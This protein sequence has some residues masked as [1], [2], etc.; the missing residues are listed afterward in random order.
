[1]AAEDAD[2]LAMA[3]GQPVTVTSPHGK[4]AARVKI[5]ELRPRNLQMFFPEANPV[6][7]SGRTDEASGVPDYNVV[8]TLSRRG[9]GDVI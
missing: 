5:A 7:A 1:M 3:D 4:V 2:A 6:L 9:A 8:V